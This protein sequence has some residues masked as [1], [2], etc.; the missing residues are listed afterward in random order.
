MK[1]GGEGEI[2]M[3]LGIVTKGF[4]RRRR[5]RLFPTRE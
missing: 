2:L 3:M 4:S 1:R 5:L